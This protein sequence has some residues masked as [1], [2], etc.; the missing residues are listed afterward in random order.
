[1]AN[2]NRYSIVV[3]IQ[4]QFVDMIAYSI[5][6]MAEDHKKQCIGRECAVTLF[7]L[8]TV[9]EQLLDRKLTIEES[10]ILS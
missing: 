9:V 3:M 5:L 10:K 6:K 2:L 4:P 8:R 1:M 7:P